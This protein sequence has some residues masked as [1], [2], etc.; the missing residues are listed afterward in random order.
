MHCGRLSG[1]FHRNCNQLTAKEGIGE[2]TARMRCT[3]PLGRSLIIFAPLDSPTAGKPD[4]LA[5]N[6]TSSYIGSGRLTDCVSVTVQRFP[7]FTI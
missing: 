3:L 7:G 4:F 5:Q 6:S 2:Q 1:E